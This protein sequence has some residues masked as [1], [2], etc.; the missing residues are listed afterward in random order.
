MKTYQ[1]PAETYSH[2]GSEL[3]ILLASRDVEFFQV[4][5]I[6]LQI[7]VDQVFPSLRGETNLSMSQIYSQVLHELQIASKSNTET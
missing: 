2:E 3:L 1:K 7:H 4:L 5:R 6:C